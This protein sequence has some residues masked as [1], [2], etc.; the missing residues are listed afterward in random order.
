[1]SIGSPHFEEFKGFTPY[2]TVGPYRA[3]DYDSLE[4]G[5]P[6]ELIRGRLI[7]SP[8][9]LPIHQTVLRILS[10]KFGD[11]EESAD[12]LCYIAPIDVVLSNDTIVQPDLLYLSE[13]RRDLV[14]KRIEGPP[15]LIVE[16]LSPGTGRRDKTEKLDLYAKYGVAE[17]W[18]V[19]P[20]M[21]AFEFLLLENGK[22]VVQ[23]QSGDRYQS[24]RLP[25]VTIDLAAFW[26]EV[27]RRLPK[28]KPTP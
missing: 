17:Y 14:K 6:Y 22:Y 2:S 24:P 18:I 1:M 15:D 10:R 21:Q 4:E 7:M 5:A 26:A 12:G 8:S 28:Q 23:Q 19:D 11:F 3:K 20:A 16:I 9:P 27:E 13:R 25:E